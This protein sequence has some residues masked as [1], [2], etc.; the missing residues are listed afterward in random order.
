MKKR[1]SKDECLRLLFHT[2]LTINQQIEGRGG[3]CR[4]LA[5]EEVY[6]VN[7]TSVYKGAPN[8][9]EMHLPQGK[10]VPLSKAVTALEVKDTTR[11]RPEVMLYDDCA[12][13]QSSDM[14]SDSVLLVVA[15]PPEGKAGVWSL[16]RDSSSQ[17]FQLA[18][19]IELPETS[20]VLELPLSPME[21]PSCV[22]E[23]MS[24]C[25][26]SPEDFRTS[27]A[28]SRL[29]LIPVL[30]MSGETGMLWTTL[31]R[32]DEQSGLWPITMPDGTVFIGD[33]WNPANLA[34]KKLIKKRTKKMKGLGNPLT[35]KKPA[36]A[37]A[38]EPAEKEPAKSELAAAFDAALGED[39]VVI[40]NEAGIEVELDPRVDAQKPMDDPIEE[41]V[42]MQTTDSEPVPAP[43]EELA[44]KTRTRKTARPAGLDLAAVVESL[45][46]PVEFDDET[47]VDALLTEL[48]DLRDLQVAAARRAA[49]LASAFVKFSKNAI[50]RYTQIRELLK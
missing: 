47:Q 21:I 26:Y 32:E 14:C 49:N 9:D 38:P 11:F 10:V 5:G 7:R 31:S 22:L 50:E 29:G 2:L 42:S 35:M 16:K 6:L 45:S 13:L 41:A 44:R 15:K 1:V 20:H 37:P 40:N 43:V 36:S 19:T 33:A 48:R 34:F 30:L 28:V 8:D 46:A 4:L 17:T 39:P 23:V 3:A 12:P 25:G 27:L 24:S 18:R